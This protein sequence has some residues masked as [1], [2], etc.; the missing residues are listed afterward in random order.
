MLPPNATGLFV[1]LFA[2]KLPLIDVP[3]DANENI[4]CKTLNFN[5][6]N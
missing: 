1:N 6:K 3:P 4:F 2:E 5:Y